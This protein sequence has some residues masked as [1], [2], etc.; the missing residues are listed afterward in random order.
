MKKM[1]TLASLVLALVLAFALTVPAFADTT[2]ASITI[3]NASKG[4]TYTAYKLFNAVVNEEGGITYT[5]TIPTDKYEVT[6]G[7]G[8]TATTSQH[9]LTE[10][11][12]TKANG[13]IGM[14]NDEEELSPLAIA[15]LKAW[16]KAQPANSGVSD[17]AEGGP[18]TLNVG[19]YGYYVVTSSIDSGAAITVT[20][21]NPTATV[22]DKN[23]AGTPSFEGNGK[24]AN[25]TSFDIGSTVTY[26][27]TFKT[28]NWIGAGED[29]TKV[30]E[31]VLTDTATSNYL[32]NV[33]VTS[34]MIGETNYKVNDEVPQFDAN[35][36]IRLPWV[37]ASGAS[38]YDNGVKVTITYTATVAGKGEGTNRVTLTYNDTNVPTVPEVTIY[39][40]DIVIDKYTMVDGVNTKLADAKFVLK[41]GE[42]KF[43]KYTAATADGNAAKV[44]WVDN[45]NDATVKTT[46]SKGVATFEGLKA[47][48]Y[49][50]VE[51]E[52]PAGYNKVAGDIGVKIIENVNDQE[53]VTGLSVQMQKKNAEEELVWTTV[54]S[55]D[56]LNETGATL[57]STGGMGTTLFYTIGGLLVVCSAILFVT[58]KRM[59][60]MA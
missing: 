30:T 34:I 43:Y 12:E 51:I 48:N 17:E 38:L 56:V 52:A 60:N 21:T 19:S 35:M 26:T 20:S 11:F 18:L 5:G 29:A 13:Q 22:V 2:P 45:Q 39:N 47:G 49:A 27:V 8:E 41:N 25:G 1:K 54:N 57:P 50:L 42:G 36:K 32:K 46:G 10:F 58:K 15:T 7:T 53:K 40:T 14:V 6:M 44:E 33:Q 4:A 16:A 9:S 3:T 24:T 55:V 59:S 31:Y 23:S 28:V 37:N